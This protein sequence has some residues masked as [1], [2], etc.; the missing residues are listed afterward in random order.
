MR[1][2]YIGK[3]HSTIQIQFERFH[4]IGDM[5]ISG[6]LKQQLRELPN[7]DEIATQLSPFYTY[8][9][10]PNP[11]IIVMSIIPLTYLTKNNYFAGA[12]NFF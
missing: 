8:N 3:T 2:K 4:Y 1:N 6:D 11:V 12:W 7:Y 9:K 5:N 10:I